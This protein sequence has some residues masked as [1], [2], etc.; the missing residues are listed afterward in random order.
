[1]T[2]KSQVLCLCTHRREY[3]PVRMWGLHPSQR[4]L[5]LRQCQ[6]PLLWHRL[7]G[8][9]DRYGPCPS[10]QKS[11]IRRPW[12]RFPK[13]LAPCVSHSFN[14]KFRVVS[15]P[16]KRFQGVTEVLKNRLGL[17]AGISEIKP[18]QI[19]ERLLNQGRIP[20]LHA[21]ISLFFDNIAKYCLF[22]LKICQFLLQRKKYS[23]ESLTKL[24]F[25]RLQSPNCGQC[26]MNS[27]GNHYALCRRRLCS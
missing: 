26:P 9:R 7:Q 22:P 8:L 23:C 4:L 19:Q 12:R 15:S 10:L 25:L 16:T 18:R 24:I 11:L 14:S 3:F 1:M 21:R 20:S 27:T 5:R 17:K 2:W 13:I 6:Y